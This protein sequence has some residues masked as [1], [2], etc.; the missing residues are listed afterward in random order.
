MS[1]ELWAEELL[2]E[3]LQRASAARQT[4]RLQSY[5]FAIL[6]IHDHSAVILSR[7]STTFPFVSPERPSGLKRSSIAQPGKAAKRT[8]GHNPGTSLAAHHKQVF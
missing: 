2:R 6:K 3:R 4:A 7:E 1:R 5:R 8:E